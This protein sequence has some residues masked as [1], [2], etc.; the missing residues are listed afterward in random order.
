MT[1]ITDQLRSRREMIDRGNGNVTDEPDYLCE[2]AAAEIERLRAALEQIADPS[3]SW[4][5]MKKIA[6]EALE[7]RRRKAISEMVAESQRLGLD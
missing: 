3:I 7:W 5:H 6:R 4:G 1:D 2:E